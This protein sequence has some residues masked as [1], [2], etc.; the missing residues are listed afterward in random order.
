[1]DKHINKSNEKQIYS[2]TTNS[3]NNNDTKMSTKDYER[4]LATERKLANY[5][6]QMS[7]LV[8]RLASKS[9]QG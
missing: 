2:T 8:D 5:K 6:E 7:Q 9:F 3:I 4:N 1:M